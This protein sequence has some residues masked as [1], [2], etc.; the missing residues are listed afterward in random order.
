MIGKRGE[1]YWQDSTPFVSVTHII[2]TTLAKPQLQYWFGQQVY[3]A[4]IADPTMSEKE[5]LQAPY[6][7]SDKAKARGSTV[8][9]ILEGYKKGLDLERFL[10]SVDEQYRGYAT[11]LW[12]WVNDYQPEFV[13]HERTV[14]SRKFGY[15][16]TLDLLAKVGDS[17]V[18]IDAKS[19]KDIYPNFWLQLCAYRQAL[20]EEGTEVD[21]M[22]VLLLKENG[23]YKYETSN[24]DLFRPFFACKVLWDWQNAD[25]MENLVRHSTRRRSA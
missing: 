8:H 19:G 17:L 13:E 20:R 16:G 15:A 11:A 4:V 6:K 5:A 12:Q 14:V 24:E 7:V 23:N 25:K 2:D 21:H 22:A 3:R 9:S 10:E 18:L 1:F